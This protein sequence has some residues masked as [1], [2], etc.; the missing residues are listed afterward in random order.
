MNFQTVP[1]RILRRPEVMALTDLTHSALH[2]EISHGRFPAPFKLTPD[3]SA[4]AVGW[5]MRAI[6]TWIDERES[7]ARAAA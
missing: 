4:R 2:R 3:P 5:S 1:N 7:Q 6:Q